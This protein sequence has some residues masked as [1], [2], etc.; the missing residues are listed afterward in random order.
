MKQNRDKLTKIIGWI[1]FLIVVGLFCLQMGY[2]LLHSRFQVEFIDNRLFYIINILIVFLLF[3]AILL[4]FTVAKGFKLIGTGFVAIFI[5]L[6]VSF[7]INSNNEVNNVTSIS[8]NFKHVLGIKENVARREAIFYRSYFGVLARPK[9]KLPYVTK[10]EFKV[11]WLAKDIAAVTYKAANNTTQQFIG[12][13][14]DRGGGRSYYYVGA[15][16][17]GKWRGRN[18]EVISNQEGVSITKD[19]KTELFLWKNIEQFGTLAV[20]LMKNNEAAWTI[21][22]NENFKVDS[23]AAEP[24]VGNITLYKAT[25]KKNQPIKLNYVGSN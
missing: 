6:N 25:M 24:T 1:L 13:Y 21:S 11:E 16:I 8:P 12:T 23:D 19:N 5:I 10:G 17:H 4:L 20:V 3:L 7:L 14:G 9:E 18:I 22:L 15:E 2:I